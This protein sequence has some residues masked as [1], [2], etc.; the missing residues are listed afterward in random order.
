MRAIKRELF[1][2]WTRPVCFGAI[3]EQR[4]LIEFNRH[5]SF[6]FQHKMTQNK[7]SGF[8]TNQE[9]KNYI[10]LLPSFTVCFDS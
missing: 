5:F 6:L 10:K 9:Q 3:L 1:Y 4:F 2:I 7:F 8:K